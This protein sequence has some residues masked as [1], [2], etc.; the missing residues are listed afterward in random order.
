[1]TMT[2]ADYGSV[3]GLGLTDTVRIQVIV[4]RGVWAVVTNSHHTDLGAQYDLFQ[5]RRS[6]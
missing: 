2:L 4:L 3:T 5:W 6:G 1:M